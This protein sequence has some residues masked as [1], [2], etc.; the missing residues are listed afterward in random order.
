MTTQITPESIS[1]TVH[2]NIPV[3]TTELLAGLYGSCPKLIRQNY[4]RNAERFV[5]GK[6]FFKLTGAELKAFK[7]EASKRGLVK[8]APTTNHLILWTERGAARHAKMLETDQA[9]E[10]F[11]KLEDCYFAKKGTPTT[12]PM[13]AQTH[14]YKYRYY[15]KVIVWDKLTNKCIELEGE[16]H[17]LER[18]ACGIARDLGYEPVSTLRR[19]EVFADGDDFITTA[20]RFAELAKR[21]GYMLVKTVA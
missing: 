13:P 6:H 12:R 5:A 11:E 2:Q 3:I 15:G 9:W 17:T 21:R 4:Q 7:N 14:Q 18:V 16:A 8:I 20:R 19:K 1:L 10:V